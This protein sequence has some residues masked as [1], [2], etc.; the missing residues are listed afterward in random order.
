MVLGSLGGW[1]VGC[2]GGRIAPIGG[3]GGR[4]FLMGWGDAAWPDIGT[5]GLPSYVAGY[6]YITLHSDV[7]FL[8]FTESGGLVC[9]VTVGGVY[10][11][12]VE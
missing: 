2:W 5:G 3:V 10:V 4:I 9:F 8:F 6:I 1:G 11:Y 7:W 12:A